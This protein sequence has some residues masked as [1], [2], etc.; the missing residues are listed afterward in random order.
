[1]G[2][3]ITAT[4]EN[5]SKM[6]DEAVKGGVDTVKFEGKFDRV[7]I[8][9]R[10]PPEV[11]ELDLTDAHIVSYAT[12]NA[13]RWRHYKGLFAGATY[14]M[15]QIQGGGELEFD[16]CTFDMSEIGVC[17][18]GVNRN[19]ERVYV[20]HCLFNGGNADGVDFSSCRKVRLEHCRFQNFHTSDTTHADCCQMWQEAGFQT[21]EDIAIR[22]NTASGVGQGFGIYSDNSSVAGISLVGNTITTFAVH[23]GHYANILPPPERN[24]RNEGW[25]C[26]NEMKHNRAYTMVG[27]PKGWPGGNWTFTSLVDAPLDIE[28]NLFGQLGLG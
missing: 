15:A 27:C 24:A 8:Y 21:I 19:A 9:N 4:P 12:Q 10:S 26:V 25:D 5:W 3:V 11:V 16:T 6:I 1:M 2:K 13:F 14:Q 7:T 22:Y 20:H 18:L 23:A 28:D 17:G